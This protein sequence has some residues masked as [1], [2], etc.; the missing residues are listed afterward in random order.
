MNFIIALAALYFFG[1]LWW[2]VFQD[3]PVVVGL[4]TVL[5][6]IIIGVKEWVQRNT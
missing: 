4:I 6:V 3:D 1:A 5:S 2:I